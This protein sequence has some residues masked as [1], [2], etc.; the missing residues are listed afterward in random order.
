MQKLFLGGLQQRAIAEWSQANR[1]EKNCIHTSLP[2]QP[3]IPNYLDT[4]TLYPYNHAPT[5]TSFQRQILSSFIGRG[6]T[7]LFTIAS[8]WR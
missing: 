3:T 1:K 4:V 5:T 6:A 2:L 7:K 8:A